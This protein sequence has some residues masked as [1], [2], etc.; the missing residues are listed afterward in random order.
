LSVRRIA[1]DRK[2]FGERQAAS[3]RLVM[4]N[5][6][7]LL[8][9]GGAL[10]TLARYLIARWFDE[11]PWAQVFPFGTF[12]VNVSGSFILGASA[13]V[14][15]ER[16][17]SL[18]GWYPLIGTGFCGGYTTFSTF[19]WETYKLVRDGSSWFAL[20]NIFGSVI[21]GFVALVLG[22]LLASLLF[23]RR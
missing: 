23:P 21:A 3:S 6:M 16:V 20:A 1:C 4:R 5:R 15:L 22:V 7:L 18:A 11:Q 2:T 19:E 14:V 13:V 17:P 9:L 10:G 8:M 12:V